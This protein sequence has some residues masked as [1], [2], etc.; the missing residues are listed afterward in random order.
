MKKGLKAI[1]FIFGVVIAIVMFYY[2]KDID[3]YGASGI[4]ILWGI[5]AYLGIQAFYE[6]NH[7]RQTIG[8]SMTN[9][10]Y[11][12]NQ[13]DSPFDPLSDGK[14]EE[15][16]TIPKDE[17][18]SVRSSLYVMKLKLEENKEPNFRKDLAQD[19][20]KIVERYDNFISEHG[21]K[22]PEEEK[23]S[24]LEDLKRCLAIFK[25]SGE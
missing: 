13:E 15:E 6:W 4:G 24:V 5:A 16:K 17:W 7:G 25:G 1:Q 11:Q 2:L 12:N 10:V 8:E 9:D 22:I 19:F 20:M 14:M 18:A 23:M 3:Y 21:D